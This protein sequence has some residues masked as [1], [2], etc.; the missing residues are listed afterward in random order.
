MK[1]F[2]Q[3]SIAGLLLLAA[4]AA[5]SQNYPSKPISLMVPYP[6]GGLSDAVARIF[7]APAGQGAGPAGDGRQS[8]RRRPA[9]WRRR[10]C[11][12]RLADGY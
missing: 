10:R 8:R 5:F 12:R 6:A 1:T 4:G 3:R 11:W 2:F 9:R 7:T